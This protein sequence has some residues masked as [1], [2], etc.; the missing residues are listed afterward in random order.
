MFNLFW[1]MTTPTE[2]TNLLRR[3]TMHGIGNARPVQFQT[4][5]RLCFIF[6]FCQTKFAQGGK[7]QI[8]RI[9]AGEGP[10]RAVG[11][12]QAGGQP[13]NQ[14]PRVIIAK[15]GNRRIPPIGM[16]FAQGMAKADKARTA[17]TFARRIKGGLLHG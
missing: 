1:R 16:L 12:V 5:V 2:L 4:V 10:S 7:E 17:R 3:Q 8:A 9:I 11:A 6:S 14:Q 15:R 13:Y